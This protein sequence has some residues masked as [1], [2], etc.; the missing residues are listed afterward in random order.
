MNKKVEKELKN[1]FEK[2]EW[3]PEE[4]PNDNK[5]KK[6]K[7]IDFY[8]YIGQIKDVEYSIDDKIIEESKKIS[9]YID[10]YKENV[11]MTPNKNDI[12]KLFKYT[13][14]TINIYSYTTGSLLYAYRQALCYKNIDNKTTL[15]D[16]FQDITKI[17]IKLLK[18]YR[19]SDYRKYMPKI[20]ENYCEGI[21]DT[22]GNT[23]DI[24][25]VYNK[26]LNNLIPKNIEEQKYNLYLFEDDKSKYV[27]LSDC[28]VNSININD[29]I[30][31]LGLIYK[32]GNK[33]SLEKS[34]KVKLNIEALLELDKYIYDNKMIRNSYNSY[35][36]V[37]NEDFDILKTK[38]IKDKLFLIVQRNKMQKLFNDNT[39]YSKIKRYVYEIKVDDKKFID[40]SED[41]ESL[42]D[43]LDYIYSL[44]DI[45]N[46]K[47]AKVVSLLK[48]KTYEE[49]TIKILKKQ[50]DDNNIKLCIWMNDYINRQKTENI[51]NYPEKEKEKKS[52]AYPFYKFQKKN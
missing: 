40:I 4:E 28:T 27:F 14:D 34:F 16:K 30:D 52:I 8:E 26:I 47:Y 25:P 17:R 32:K 12:I 5:W 48:N 24:F 39:D 10:K 19:G 35:Y 20:K 44:N 9:G 23:T 2:E 42:K 50:K 3:L 31:E 11:K 46:E 29:Y 22:N 18:C 41:N 36:Y 37:I 6:I 21:D 38:E 7:D 33:I 49:L 43:K 15:L 51:I 1:F 13:D 45:Y